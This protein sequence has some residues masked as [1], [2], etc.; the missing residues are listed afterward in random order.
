MANFG[1]C[2]SALTKKNSETTGFSF[3]GYIFGSTSRQENHVEKKHMFQVM[4]TSKDREKSSLVTTAE[5]PGCL[6]FSVFFLLT[7][8]VFPPDSYLAN[9]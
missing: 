3:L 4:V 2:I 5:S 9:G 7:S 8:D 6:C 1:L